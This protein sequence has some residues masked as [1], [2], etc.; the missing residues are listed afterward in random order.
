M[1]GEGIGMELG[2]LGQAVLA[3]DDMASVMVGECI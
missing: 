2:P 3:K 1:V